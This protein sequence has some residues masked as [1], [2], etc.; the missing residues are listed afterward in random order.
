LFK[1]KNHS[2]KKLS[3]DEKDIWVFFELWLR[4]EGDVGA[5]DSVVHEDGDLGHEFKRTLDFALFIGL[6]HHF[7]VVKVAFLKLIR[8]FRVEVL[9]WFR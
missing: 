1:L 3:G 5:H 6:F 8:A 4:D 7:F 9:V 2:L